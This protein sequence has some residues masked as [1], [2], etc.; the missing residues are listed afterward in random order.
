MNQV[1]KFNTIVKHVE[2]VGALVPD[3]VDVKVVTIGKREIRVKDLQGYKFISVVMDQKVLMCAYKP[4]GQPIR[5]LD[6]HEDGLE[7]TYT[8][9]IKQPV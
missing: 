3:T 5:F 9:V 7:L 2:T 8:A 6:G 4:V 1:D